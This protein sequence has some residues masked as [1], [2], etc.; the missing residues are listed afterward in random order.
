M[1]EG[2]HRVVKI[3]QS[4]TALVKAGRPVVQAYAGK[5]GKPEVGRILCWCPY[6]DGK[7]YVDK[8]MK[9]RDVA[10]IE[11][12]GTPFVVAGSYA[13]EQLATM[14]DNIIEPPLLRQAKGR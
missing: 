9:R 13:L 1:F 14:T 3:S 12:V 7:V 6:C 4:V 5:Q 2:G 8:E 10:V 11:C